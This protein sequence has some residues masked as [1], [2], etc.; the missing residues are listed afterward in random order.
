MDFSLT[1]HSDIDRVKWLKLAVNG[2][3]NAVQEYKLSTIETHAG[4]AQYHLPTRRMDLDGCS[5]KGQ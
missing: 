2:C 5:G 1:S 4:K 3:E